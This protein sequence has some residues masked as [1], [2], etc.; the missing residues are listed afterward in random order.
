MSESR[1]RASA[2]AVTT[3]ATNSGAALA[4]SH[5]TLE[6]AVEQP[7]RDHEQ[8]GQ[9]RRTTNARNIGRSRCWAEAG[10]VA[11][12]A[13]EVHQH[14]HHHDHQ[15]HQVDLAH[16]RPSTMT[17]PPPRPDDVAHDVAASRPTTLSATQPTSA[18]AR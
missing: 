3:P 8:L 2:S 16:A 13:L 7:A 6:A 15:V 9:D 10:A 12:H 1:R 18:S 11:Q 4:T 17:A 5:D 14:R